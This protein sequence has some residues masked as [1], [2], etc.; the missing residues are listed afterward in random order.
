MERIINWVPCLP[1]NLP[2]R[3]PFLEEQK[4]LPSCRRQDWL[5]L[6]GD[7]VT[8]LLEHPSPRSASVWRSVISSGLFWSTGTPTHCSHWSLMGN[9]AP[10]HLVVTRGR[11]WLV[12]RPHCNLIAI[13]KDSMRWDTNLMTPKQES[14][15]SLTSRMT[16]I[17][18]TP[19]LVL[20]PQVYMMTPT[21]VEMRQRARQI[22]ETSTSK[23]WGTS[24][25]S[26]R[27]HS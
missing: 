5:W 27:G 4:C 1:E 19:E 15:S 11:H 13:R 17:P 2:L 12:H 8:Y 21:R 26:D 14:A 9:T 23:P 6:P 18:V 25:Y 16:V 20:A 24:W 10:P 3:F 22:M 7:Q